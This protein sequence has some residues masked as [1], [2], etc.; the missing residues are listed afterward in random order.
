MNI[1]PVNFVNFKS[2]I[3]VNKMNTQAQ[4]AFMTQPLKKDSFTKSEFNVDT[5]IKSL[6]NQNLMT[7]I[8]KT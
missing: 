3:K 8:Y 2:S 7:G 1:S 4:R 5:A 6:I